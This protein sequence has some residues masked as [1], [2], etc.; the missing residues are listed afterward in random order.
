MTA[1]RYCE[2]MQTMLSRLIE[3]QPHLFNRSSS[4]ILHDNIEAHT[5]EQLIIS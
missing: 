1:D 3:V 2:V 5:A 4:Q